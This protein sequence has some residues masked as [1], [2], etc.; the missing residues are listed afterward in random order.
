M[1]VNVCLVCL[2]HFENEP[3]S[4]SPEHIDNSLLLKRFLK[5]AQ[6]YL[7]ISSDT[8]EY[9]PTSLERESFCKKCELAVINPICQVYQEYLSTQLRL[10]WEL[11]QLGKLLDNSKQSTGSVESK[12]SKLKSLSLQ[13][14][15]DGVSGMN[16]F[17]TLLTE[18]CKLKGKETLPFIPFQRCKTPAKTAAAVRSS[19]N[20]VTNLAGEEMAT[21]PVS[22][23]ENH[24]K[25][26]VQSLYYHNEDDDDLFFEPS[27]LNA[28]DPLHLHEDAGPVTD[29]PESC[30]T[31]EQGVELSVE[32]ISIKN[33]ICPDDEDNTD[34]D[35][36][37]V[38][39]RE[40]F[41]T[42]N[43]TTFEM[44][45]IQ[46]PETSICPYCQK[47]FPRRANLN[48]HI[49]K[50]HPEQQYRGKTCTICFREFPTRQKLQ[51][52]FRSVHEGRRYS[53]SFCNAS[54]K[55]KCH[56][57]AHIAS[58]HK[59]EPASCNL[60][61]KVLKNIKY[62]KEHMAAVHPD[63]AKKQNWPKCPKCNKSFFRKTQIQQHMRSCPVVDF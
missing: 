1:T 50:V 6:N 2:N 31:T 37:L 17:R 54:F 61:G 8:D 36:R 51:G 20:Y 63:P 24:V 56:L 28:T 10:S 19:E 16:E 33:E 14:G 42:D 32:Q 55:I 46:N 13:L 40:E 38:Q 22:H 35:P 57:K 18:K 4:I 49:A 58:I 5:F 15:I 27:S 23:D 53:C 47:S 60:C 7:Q 30:S 48:V 3:S 34:P 59:P 45:L 21:V 41:D 44:G 26:E 11:G 52:H 25:I 12:F 29:Y 39:T 43:D 9:F 62:L